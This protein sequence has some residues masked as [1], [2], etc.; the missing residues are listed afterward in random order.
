MVNI[1][2]AKFFIGKDFHEGL[3]I[4]PV[5]LLA[6][7]LLGVYL[8][9][10][11]WYKLNNKT[12][13]GAVFMAIGAILT[14]VLNIVLVPAMGYA[15]AAWTHLIVYILMVAISYYYGQKQYPVPYE[16]V[17]L[18][19]YIV[20]PVILVIFL[21]Y[22]TGASL[23]VKLIIGNSLFLLFILYAVKTENVMDEIKMRVKSWSK[24]E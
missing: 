10:S 16:N 7:L 3:K 11:I 4:V 13:Y 8:N 17:K 15:G 19:L 6:N 24:L 5:V 9:L 21:Q 22:F 14:I 12:M 20:I 1:D 2:I 18:I 23:I